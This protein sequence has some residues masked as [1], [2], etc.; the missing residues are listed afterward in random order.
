MLFEFD[1]Y[2]FVFSYEVAAAAKNLFSVF[3]AVVF[4]DSFFPAMPDASFAYF[5]IRIDFFS[6]LIALY[7]KCFPPHIVKMN[8]RGI[9]KTLVKYE[10]KKPLIFLCMWFLKCFGYEYFERYL[11]IVSFRSPTDCDPVALP[12]F[13]P[14]LKMPKYGS[15]RIL[16]F[17]A[18]FFSF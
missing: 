11:L 4:K 6:A 3:D 2:A 9:I 5:N 16:Y 12:I 14:Y 8:Y 17:F 15:P 10:R 18:I 1:P 7:G 13:S